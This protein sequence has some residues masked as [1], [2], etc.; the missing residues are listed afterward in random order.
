MVRE[1]G[2]FRQGPVLILLDTHVVVWLRSGDHR[3]G[4]LARDTV[5]RAL[6]EGRAA[7]STISFWEIGMLAEK[8]RLQILLDL[9][10]WRR[11]L[12]D[13]GLIEI[14]VDGGIAAHAGQLAAMHGDPADRIIVATT[15]KGHRLVTADQKILDWSGPLNR[16]RATD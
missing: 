6:Q 14:P 13:Q 2:R 16:L 1:I 8:G 4:P 11:E 9:D 10:A 15:L 7:V 3:L 5:E 12:L